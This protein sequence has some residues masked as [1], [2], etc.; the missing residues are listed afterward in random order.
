M[1]SRSFGFLLSLPRSKTQDSPLSWVNESWKCRN[2]ISQGHL[3]KESKWEVTP[4][5]AGPFPNAYGEN[6]TKAFAFTDSSH[7]GI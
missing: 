7:T 5:A 6:D 4:E 3:K 2:L 1:E